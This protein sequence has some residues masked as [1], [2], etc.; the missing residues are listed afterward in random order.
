MIH[1]TRFIAAIVLGLLSAEAS[2]IPP[3]PPAEAGSVVGTYR[4]GARSLVVTMTWN[5]KLSGH[6]SY[7]VRVAGKLLPDAD[8][9]RLDREIKVRGPFQAVS[10]YCADA[11]PNQL[12]LHRYTPTAEKLHVYFKGNAITN[13][14]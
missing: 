1:A 8:A 5:Y 14:R 3:P 7:V 10:V 2:A 13:I 9:Q 12:V 6:R 11:A 4:C